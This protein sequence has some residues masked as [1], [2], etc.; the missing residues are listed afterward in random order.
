M[1]TKENIISWS[2]KTDSGCWEWKKAIENTGYGAQQFK[3]RKCGAHRVSYQI[4]NG[5]I[6]AGLSVLH[7][8]D[9]R[10]C[11]NPDHL[12]LGT[13]AEN[14]ADMVAKGRSADQR[15]EKAPWAKL[16]KKSV[17]EIIRQ[18]SARTMSQRKIAVMF[19]ISQAQVSQ[20][21]N[22]KRWSV[23]GDEKC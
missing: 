1:I 10:K 16:T 15:G 20:I 9:N 12:F 2:D 8:C 22:R 4:F 19:G 11:V 18:A 6:Q 13:Q 21:L 14:M 17:L 5:D 3:G 23:I 7:R